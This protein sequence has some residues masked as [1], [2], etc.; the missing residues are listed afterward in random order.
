MGL[1][2]IALERILSR[3]MLEMPPPDAIKLAWEYFN[4]SPFCWYGNSSKLNIKTEIF[5]CCEWINF[6]YEI[7][8]ILHFTQ[9]NTI[10]GTST[11]L[12]TNGRPYGKK[13]IF[14]VGF[15]KIVRCDFELSFD[16]LEIGEIQF[17]PKKEM[18]FI[19]EPCIPLF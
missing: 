18:Q 11:D 7:G 5:T 12:D 14:Y 10:Y 6:G 8:T 9:E 17:I 3:K 4:I 19:E 2:E 13:P 16:A 1:K 15:F